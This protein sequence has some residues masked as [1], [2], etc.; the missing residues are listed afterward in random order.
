MVTRTRLSV[1]LR[2]DS[3][4]TAR[5]DKNQRACTSTSVNRQAKYSLLSIRTTLSLS[6][7]VGDGLV[8]IWACENHK[9][10]FCRVVSCRYDVNR[11]SCVLFL[12]CVYA[13]WTRVTTVGKLRQKFYVAVSVGLQSRPAVHCWHVVLTGC[14]RCPVLRCFISTFSCAHSLLYFQH[15][16]ILRSILHTFELLRAR[17]AV[18]QRQSRS[19]RWLHVLGKMRV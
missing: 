6:L 17:I 14:T 11:P 8:W 9:R 13:L 15:S 1:T 7:V 5:H 19:T 3:H 2:V 4:Y 12:S 10:V 16:R 18:L